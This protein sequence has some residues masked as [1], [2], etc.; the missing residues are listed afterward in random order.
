MPDDKNSAN[1][2]SANGRTQRGTSADRFFYLR[3]VL[4]F[5]ILVLVII[6]VVVIA[7]LYVDPNILVLGTAPLYLTLWGIFGSVTAVLYSIYRKFHRKEF[8]WDHFVKAFFRVILGGFFATISF[9]I[10]VVILKYSPWGIGDVVNEALAKSSEHGKYRAALTAEEKAET[11]YAVAKAELEAVRVEAGLTEGGPTVE[12]YAIRTLEDIEENAAK[13]LSKTQTELSAFTATFESAELKVDRNELDRDI[14]KLEARRKKN[15]DNILAWV[16]RWESAER[17]SR[18]GDERVIAEL[19]ANSRR[20]IELEAAI[21]ELE[22]AKSAG[23]ETGELLLLPSVKESPEKGRLKGRSVR[24]RPKLKSGL[25]EYPRRETESGGIAID[26]ELTR[27]RR[28]KDM[29]EDEILL[30]A[31]ESAPTEDA[32]SAVTTLRENKNEIDKK[33]MVAES[34]MRKKEEAMTGALNSEEEEYKYPPW[35]N[36]LYVLIAIIAGFFIDSVPRKLEALRDR[37]LGKNRPN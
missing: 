36:P 1:D 17:A 2:G 8:G 22:V 20:V 25:K 5:F 33:L 37:Y 35:K 26:D 27:L 7:E 24:E 19:E 6:A 30:L 9:F 10:I 14:R 3:V 16:A 28:E 15:T 29:L 12:G 23:A 13:T 32:E 21:K 4:S 11:E 18:K 34:G 31:G